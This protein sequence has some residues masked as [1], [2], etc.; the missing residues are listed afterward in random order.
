MPNLHVDEAAH[1]RISDAVRRAEETTSGEIVTILAERSDS[2]ADVALCWAAAA[3]FIAITAMAIAPDFY[4]GWLDWLAGGWTQ[5]WSPARVFWIAALVFALKFLSMMLLQLW[6][7]LKYL[8]IPGRIKTARV[9]ARAVTCFKVGADRRTQGR[10]GILI[11]LSMQEHRAEIVADEAITGKVPDDV[12]GEAML[13]M[14]E[15]LRAG[16]IADAVIAGVERTGAVLTHHFPR[17]EDDENEIPDRLI[18]L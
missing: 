3:G 10:T 7:P 12:W 13:A 1:V 4:L 17:A 15:Q 5:E 11:Y 14:L 16:H 9:H 2:Y 18:E 8:L 6:T